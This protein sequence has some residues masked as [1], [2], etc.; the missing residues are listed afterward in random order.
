MSDAIGKFDIQEGREMAWHG[1]TKVNP[2]LSLQNCWLTTWD[3]M[4][5]P[6]I[7][8][9]KKTPFAVLGVTDD[10][11]DDILNEDGEP[12]GETFPL[13]I[14]RPYQVK[15]FKPV[16]NQGEKGLLARI[17]AAI[18]GHGLTLDSAGT[19][20]NRGRLFLSFGLA[21][22]KFQAAGREFKSFLNVG[23]GND[24][25]SP[26]WVNTSNICT[27]CNN[28]FTANL[29]DAGMIMSVK[30]TQFSDFKLADMGRAIKAMLN[31]QTAFAKTLGKLADVK[32]D[33]KTAREFF[34]GFVAP[35][36]ENGL[37]TRAENT[38]ERLIQLFTSG[39]G[40]DGNDFSDVFQAMTDYYTHEGASQKGDESAQWKN[41]VSSEFGAGKTAKMDAWN[42]LT[43]EKNRK[44]YVSMGR[45]VLKLTADEARKENA[46]K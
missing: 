31:G 20:Y 33:E 45:K 7:V 34:A 9:G 5:R 27:V 35:N 6:V 25:S 18:E 29:E 2:E 14:G 23:N 10:C 28:T 4:P 37:S 26:L 19:V 17:G 11:Q 40:N 38:V 30:K 8:D 43:D 39:A 42:I 21:D 15:S 1:K 41:F 13:A 44:A 12:T 36:V 22:A 16:L 46:A 3:Y 24:M 32:C